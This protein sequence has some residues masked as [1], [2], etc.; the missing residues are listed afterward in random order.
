[1]WW[2]ELFEERRAVEDKLDR[3]A[4]RLE[5]IA[6]RRSSRGRRGRERVVDTCH[7]ECRAKHTSYRCT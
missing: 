4:G 6:P 3:S 5:L 2:Q 1:M 7:W